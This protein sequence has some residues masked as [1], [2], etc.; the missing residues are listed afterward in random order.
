MHQ[1]RRAE[2]A[3]N[4]SNAT[5]D[6]TEVRRSAQGMVE[7]IPDDW[8]CVGCGETFGEWSHIIT[9]NCLASDHDSRSERLGEMECNY[10]GA[11][12]WVPPDNAENTGPSTKRGSVS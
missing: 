4:R 12:E 1:L 8:L 10:C 9:E 7:K 3:V 6:G 2:V 11:Q 5:P